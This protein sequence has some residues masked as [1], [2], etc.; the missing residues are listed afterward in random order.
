[1]SK[2]GMGQSY[3]TPHLV[4]FTMSNSN[5][6]ASFV[7]ALVKGRRHALQHD[8]EERMSYP[9]VAKSSDE[10]WYVRSDNLSSYDTGLWAGT[11]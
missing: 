2:A 4:L 9:Q 8:T 6:L 10:E 5:N 7:A 3:L 1:M 11:R